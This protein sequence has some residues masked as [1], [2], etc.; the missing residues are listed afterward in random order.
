MV[1]YAR[2]HVIKNAVFTVDED[3]YAN[4]ATKIRLVPDQDTQTLRTMV[5]DGTITDTDSPVWEL[6]LAGVQ[7]FGALSLGAAL[8]TAAAAGAD[9]DVVY[10]PK[11]GTGQDKATF[12]IR[13]TQIPFG[14]E[15]G[16]FR[17]FDVT[18]PVIGAPV[19]TQSA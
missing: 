9:L 2:A 13:P 19:F 3:D 4:Q 18:I 10:Q 11:A 14:G 15:Q 17:T 8:R 1:A 5:P 16:N 7:D 12:T 6:E